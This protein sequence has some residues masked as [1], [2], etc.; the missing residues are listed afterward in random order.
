MKL[1][2]EYHIHYKKKYSVKS[3]YMRV[4]F[5]DENKNSYDENL[6]STISQ[7][8]YQVQTF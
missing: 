1:F 4:S 6:L 8:Q 3:I 7:Y 2:V 5:Y